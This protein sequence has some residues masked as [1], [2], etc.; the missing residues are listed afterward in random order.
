MSFIV[1]SGHFMRPKAN[2]IFALG[3]CIWC[4]MNHDSGVLLDLQVTAL[5]NSKSVCSAAKVTIAPMPSNVK[6]KFLAFNATKTFDNDSEDGS[7][8]SR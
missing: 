3:S 4:K 7:A 1:L 2:I 8:V 6:S 5:A